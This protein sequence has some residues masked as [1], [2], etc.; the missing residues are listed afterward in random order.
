MKEIEIDSYSKINLTLNI[1]TKRQDGYHNIETIMQ[2]VNLADRIFI[3]K[4]KE[5][6]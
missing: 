2:S 5:E 4:E 3:K 6:I 1:L